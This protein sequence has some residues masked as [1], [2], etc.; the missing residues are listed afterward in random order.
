M[1]VA[2][3]LIN[4]EIGAIEDV[5]ASL[6]KIPGVVEA[7]SVYGVHDIVVKVNVESMDALRTIVTERIRQI[8]MVE[9]VN[10][11]IVIRN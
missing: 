10:T 9:S 8:E 6:K 1:P 2:F 3:V 4:T 7:H 5:L 11:M